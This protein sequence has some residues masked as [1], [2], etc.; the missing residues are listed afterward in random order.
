MGQQALSGLKV[1]DLGHYRAG[2]YCTK[3]LADY[4][5]EVIKIEKPESGDPARTIGPFP[6]DIPHPEKSGLFHYLN[7]NKKGITLNLKTKTGVKL[8]MALVE[9]V[10]VVVENFS[11]RVMPELGLDYQRLEKIKPAL[12]MTSIS[13]FGQTGPY[14]NFKA[15]DLT[16]QAMGGW[17]YTG[18]SPD[19]EPLKPG[20]SFADYVG[21]LSASVATTTAVL[22][23]SISGIGQHVDISIQ[24]NMVN[25]QAYFL[26]A[27]SY[28]GEARPRNG[29]PFPFTILPCKDDYIGVNILTQGQWELMCQFMDMPELI[30]DPRFQD[31]LSRYLHSAE[32]TEAI[33]PWLKTK[34]REELFFEGQEWRIPFCLIPKVDE[35]LDFEHH[36][37][38]KYFMDA[39]YRDTGKVTQPGA[40]FK[41]SKTP[42]QLKQKAPLLGEHNETVFC[43]MLGYGKNDLVRLRENGVI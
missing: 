13:N 14:K 33:T 21:G 15:H 18:G 32:I 25:T 12:V 19:R 4:G 36:K 6:E 24:E 5:A 37:D 42:W 23:R 41:M 8:F 1:L 27:Q 10:D 11:P 30:E 7:A 20:G 28:T 2:P 16:L 43:D 40:P 35:I 9:K 38:R 22:S 3:L 34:G 26:V 31:G 29:S 17:M 39:D